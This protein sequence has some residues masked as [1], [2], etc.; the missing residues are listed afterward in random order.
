MFAAS[1]YVFLHSTCVFLTNV[2][3][4]TH[5]HRSH[6]H[7]LVVPQIHLAKHLLSKKK[8]NRY[9]LS[10]Y[11]RIRLQKLQKYPLYYLEPLGKSQLGWEIG[12]KK[13]NGG[14]DGCF[15]IV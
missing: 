12:W 14:V 4:Q 13:V 1:A 2:I 3:I 11:L 8:R 9:L 6:T 10:D 5:N 7:H 15:N